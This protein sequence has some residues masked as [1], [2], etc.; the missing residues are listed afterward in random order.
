MFVVVA[1]V[2]IVLVCAASHHSTG[3]VGYRH[4]FHGDLT[5]D[6]PRDLCCTYDTGAEFMIFFYHSFC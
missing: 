3:S 4:H 1:V 2:V 5:G 6:V